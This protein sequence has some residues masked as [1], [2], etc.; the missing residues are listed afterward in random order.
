M[1]K[2]SEHT[3]TR[4]KGEL[5]AYVLR[6]SKAASFEQE[7]R[8]P[9]AR[10]DHDA[11]RSHLKRPPFVAAGSKET[12]AHPDGAIALHENAIDEAIGPYV[13]PPLHGSGKVI[14]TPA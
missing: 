10:S 5:A 11:P 7:R 3:K 9:S 2:A 8:V 4:V 13:G 1:I 12:T 6:V 14:S